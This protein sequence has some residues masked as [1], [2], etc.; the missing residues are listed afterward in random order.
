[1]GPK[2]LISEKA[3]KK[4][5]MNS[6]TPFMHVKTINSKDAIPAKTSV[7]AARSSDGKILIR[8]R[9]NT[10]APNC[11]SCRFRLPLCPMDRVIA[12]RRPK[13]GLLSN[14]LLSSANPTAFPIKIMAGAVS[15]EAYAWVTSVPNLAMT[16]F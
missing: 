9:S 8:G 10:S 16:F 6:V 14:Q 7:I 12:K 4:I 15:F 2:L 1:M 3:L 11:S 5:S 13:R